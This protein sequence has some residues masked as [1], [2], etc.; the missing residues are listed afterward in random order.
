MWQCETGVWI[1]DIVR[2]KRK[3]LERQMGQEVRNINWGIDQ[4]F[5]W[6]H[7]KDDWRYVYFPAKVRSKLKLW[8]KERQNL[9]IKGRE[10]FPLS[11]KTCGRILRRWWGN[12]GF[13]HT[14]K[15]GSGN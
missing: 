10:L 2:I 14:D 13:K 11:E 4:I 15:V 5:T 6:D 9:Q 8:Q 12:V 3:G 1:S 7:K